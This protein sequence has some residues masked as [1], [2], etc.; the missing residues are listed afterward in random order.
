M[1]TFPEEYPGGPPQTDIPEVR[2][3]ERS[4]FIV[5]KSHHF[6]VFSLPA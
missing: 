3:E 5:R 4:K 2:P 1:P 6:C